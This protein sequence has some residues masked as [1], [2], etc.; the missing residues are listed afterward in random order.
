MGVGTAL[1]PV[2]APRAVGR[3]VLSRARTL[4]VFRE[5]VLGPLGTFVGLFL[6]FYVQLVIN[7]LMVLC[8]FLEK[9]MAPHSGTLA[10]KIPWMEEPGKLESMGSQRF[11]HD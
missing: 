5:L 3:G 8:G 10:W 2:P 9:E 7:M 6:F 11:G 1:T 4:L